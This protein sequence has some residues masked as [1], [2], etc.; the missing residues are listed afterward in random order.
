[1]TGHPGGFSAPYPPLGWHFLQA[2][3]DGH[4][5]IHK[6]GLRVI[7]DCERKGDGRLWAH[8]SFSRK[9]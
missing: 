1:M 5:F 4:A 2:W 3:G 7:I 9:N 6:N 8:V